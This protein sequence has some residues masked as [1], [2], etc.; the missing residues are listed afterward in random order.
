MALEHWLFSVFCRHSLLPISASSRC[1]IMSLHDT[2]CSSDILVCY[3]LTILIMRDFWWIISFNPLK[4]YFRNVRP[5]MWS[6]PLRFD[7][8]SPANK[9]ND[10][11]RGQTKT[12]CLGESRKILS[13]RHSY[14]MATLG[15]T[16]LL[17]KMQ[18]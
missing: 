5:M 8:S 17:S 10:Q 7:F 6:A 12:N 14:K 4:L 13:R 18:K 9:E 3:F 2:I 15:L 1:N 11:V 16:L